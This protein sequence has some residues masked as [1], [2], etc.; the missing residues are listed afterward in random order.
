MVQYYR[1]M[2]IRQYRVLD[3]LKE[4]AI[5]PN[6]REILCNDRLEVDLRDISVMVSSWTLLNYHDC[7]F[8]SMN[9]QMP[10]INSW[11]LLSV[12]NINLLISFQE[13]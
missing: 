2:W 13:I 11:V 7:K 3:S 10:L 1:D 9:T 8:H 4:A 6:C 12:K 5:V